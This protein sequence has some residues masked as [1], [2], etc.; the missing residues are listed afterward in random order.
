M[1]AEKKNEG[2]SNGEK[3]NS[4]SILNLNPAI[5]TPGMKQYLQ[6][7]KQHPDCLVMLRMGDFYEMFYE[8]AITA[9]KELEITL[10]AR[11]KGEK[12]APLA[13][14]PYHAV[15]TYLGKL[16]KKGYKVAIVEQLEDPKQ[17]QGLVK[18]GLVRIVTPGTV[19]EPGMLNEKENN[20][21]LALT[22]KQ[23]QFAAAWCELSTGEFC[24]TLLPSLAQLFN[25]IARLNP[26]EVIIP[27]SLLVNTELVQRTKNTGCFLS[28]LED[29]YFSIDTARRTVLDH[30]HI[31]NLDS[32]DLEE[33]P[34]NVA[35]SGALLHYLTATQKNSLTHLKKIAVRSNQHTLLL[36]AGTIRNLELI[37]NIR[38]GSSRGTLL[39][40]LDKTVTVMGARL[41]KRWIKEPLLDAGA[42]EQ[43]WQALTALNQN[44]ILREE[45][46]AVLEKVYDL[47]RIIS[48]I[49][50]GNAT[51]R[52]LVSLQ[53]SLEQM[54]QLKQKVGGM[55]SELLQSIGALSALSEITAMLQAALREDPP[56]TVR[57]GGII[58]PDYHPELQE[59]S[60]LKTNARV[61]IQQL[62][63]QERQRTGITTLKIGFTNVFG[64]FIEVT[65]KNIS[66]VPAQYIRKQTTANSERY[67]T[68]ELKTI[69]EKILTAQERI[70]ELEYSLF[71]NLVQ[72]VAAKT[73]EIQALAINVAVLDVLCSLAAA[74]QEYNYVQP[75]LVPQPRLQIRKGRHP[76]VEQMQAGF[77]AND[78]IVD[79]GTMMIITGPN[80]SGKSTLMRQVA[81]ITLMAQMGSFVPA[82]QAVL[83]MVDRVFTRVGAYD[84][85]SSGQSTFMVEMNETAAILNSATEKSLIILD[86]IGR[87]TSTFDGVAI[88]WSVAEHIHNT[89]KARTM[90]S[91]HYHVMNKLAEKFPRIKNY[92]LAVKE[93]KGEVIFLRKLLE[94][95]TDES[96]GIHVAQLAGLPYEVVE[97]AREIQ[98]ILQKDDE[99]VRK[100]KAKRLE[101]QR[102]L[103][104]F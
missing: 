12:R 77:I 84:D 8:D 64:Y 2:G 5:L 49:N 23:D 19:I 55:P 14:V 87:G 67:I 16:V 75:E 104:G 18:R 65:K 53:H 61:Y 81:V 20:Y 73:E 68:E 7:K 13:G 6:V 3:T 83:G 29:Y 44:I 66:L 10:T 102:S 58:K 63:E 41:L 57:E 76:M 17:A 22:C 59:L 46:R 15:E 24:T 92:N 82:E 51:P 74:A 30:F 31:L 45:I 96:Y 89:I 39:A 70:Q 86:E 50:Y 60:A 47:E 21:I 38:D 80:M 93:V 88:A 71:Q 32:F 26:S 62:E 99:M 4:E 11:G 27:E 42:I 43:R 1:A 54:P 90:F 48:R 40:V 100:L 103:E 94:G 72:A 97:R 78:I 52:D 34:L 56:V 101:E 98:A 95:G 85:V 33:R 9:S 36:D 25:E 28:P 79:P 69:E 37:K 91:T 35:V